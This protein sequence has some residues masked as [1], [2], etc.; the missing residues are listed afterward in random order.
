MSQSFEPR[1]LTDELRE[2]IKTTYA[3]LQANTPGFIVRRPQSHMI[4]VASR[5]LASTGGVALI[6]AG[7]G[8]GKSLGYLTAGVPV[9]LA[10][11]RKLVLSTGTVALQSQ[12]YDRDVPAFLKATG[13]TASVALLKGRA[14]YFCPYKAVDAGSAGKDELFGDAGPLYDAPLSSADQA[15]V[16]QLRTAFERGIWGGDLDSPPTPVP[17]AVRPHVTTN[18]AG[19]LG[20]KCPFVAEC[21]ALKARKTAQEAQIVVVNHALL[22][23]ALTLSAETQEPLLGRPGNMLL[24]VDEGHHL[25]AVA[26]EAGAAAAALGPAIKR[27]VKLPPLLGR[28]FAILDAKTL[29]GFEPQ[30]VT[31]MV[32][33]YQKELKAL[34]GDIERAWTPESGDKEPMWRA[35]HGKL[36]ETWVHYCEL[37]KSLASD[38]VKVIGAASTAL[39]KSAKVS[40]AD[41]GKLVTALGQFAE[42]MGVQQVLWS[43]WA[44]TDLPGLPPYARWLTLTK[45]GDVVCHCSPS[46]ASSLLRQA[47]WDQV[48]STVVTSATISAGGD[49]ETIAAEMGVPRAA[50]RVSLPS[51]FDLPNQA[52]LIVPDMQS[53]PQD[54]QAHTREVAQYLAEHLRSDA[55]NLVLFTSK[56]RMHE[57]FGLLPASIT[58]HVLLQGQEPLQQL[59]KR[60]AERIDQGMGSILF[61]MNSLGEGVD[62]R[63][64]YCTRVFITSLTFPVPSDPVLATLSEWYEA[65]RMNS[66]LKLAVPHAIRVLTQFAGRLIRS[67]TDTGEIHILDSR[68]L[69]KRYGSTILDALPP[70]GRQLG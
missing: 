10:T 30:E 56:V 21:P 6:E 23:A 34:K 5:T 13:I 17:P 63:G 54:R 36:P 16:S 65:N 19:C 47:V 66:F 15:V 69:S 1:R 22:L 52:K 4:G 45:D 37:L 32:V 9:A 42:P 12:L 57:V 14:R 61:G 64:A 51:P 7:T 62:L 46:S 28:V 60:H 18:A 48:D 20:R 55:G 39:S 68:L 31:G 25:P 35:S 8:V 43:T 40:D 59:V 29:G 3:Q 24:V 50:E 49:F 26:I 2:Q 38:L 53:Q 58:A 41:R 11:G 33:D 27:L 70:F 44:S 67:A